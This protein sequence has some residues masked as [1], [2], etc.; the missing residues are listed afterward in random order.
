MRGY[1]HIVGIMQLKKTDRPK[2]H[3]ILH[4]KRLK[5]TPLLSA[6]TPVLRCHFSLLRV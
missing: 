6:A 4:I 1:Q 5:F 2:P 3:S